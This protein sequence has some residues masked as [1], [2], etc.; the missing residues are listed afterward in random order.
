MSKMAPFKLGYFED[1]VLHIQDLLCNNSINVTY[2]QCTRI[3]HLVCNKYLKYTFCSLRTN[4]LKF[5]KSL[6]D[7]DE[8]SLEY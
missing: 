1:I 5:G 3:I 4:E 8:Y 2:A 7:F 6:K